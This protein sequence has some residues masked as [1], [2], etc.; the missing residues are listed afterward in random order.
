MHNLH[1]DIFYI[2]DPTLAF[3]GIPYYTATFVFFEYQAIAAAG[4]LS[5]KVDIPSEIE[6]K[7]EYEERSK[8][9]GYGRNFHSM[10]E[11]EVQYVGELV[12]WVNRDIAERGGSKVEGLSKKWLDHKEER[13]RL[14]TEVAAGNLPV[15]ALRC[16]K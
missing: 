15:E 14:F 1:K 2:P 16:F 11:E 9:K 10:R 4:V 5:G 13:V 7:K 8:R 12:E 6:M 3:V